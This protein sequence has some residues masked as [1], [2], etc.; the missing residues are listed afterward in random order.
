MPILPTRLRGRFGR[1]PPHQEILSQR[2][3]LP[4]H[5]LSVPLKAEG[6]H[7]PSFD[8]RARNT[9][10]TE[11]YR[12]RVCGSHRRSPQG[13]K[14]LRARVRTQRARDVVRLAAFARL[15]RPLPR[16]Y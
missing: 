14:A 6:P 7:C 15:L 3:A 16:N 13:R 8:P 1:E 5:V 9:A 4:V 2:E 12:G 11:D 10:Q